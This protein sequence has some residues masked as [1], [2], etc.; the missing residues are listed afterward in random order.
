MTK[1]PFKHSF[2]LSATEIKDR[3]KWNLCGL[4]PFSH[5]LSGPKEAYRG[6]VAAAAMGPPRGLD[7][8]R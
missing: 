2:T 7:N 1:I 3:Q 5:P 4:V 6:V 8:D